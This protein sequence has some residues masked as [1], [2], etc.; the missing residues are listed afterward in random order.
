MLCSERHGLLSSPLSAWCFHLA[1]SCERA[2]PPGGG[3]TALAHADVPGGGGG[4]GRRRGEACQAGSGKLK[5]RPDRQEGF[6]LGKRFPPLTRT[7][8]RDREGQKPWAQVLKRVHHSGCA[9]SGTWIPVAHP[10]QHGWASACASGPRV[11]PCYGSS[12]AVRALHVERAVQL[13]VA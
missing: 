9:Q 6:K 13:V 2:S 1:A 11:G 3:G 4:G 7:M 8:S 12:R 5:D 10:P